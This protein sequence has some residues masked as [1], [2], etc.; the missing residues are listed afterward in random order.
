M[1]N[2][3]IGSL[4]PVALLLA[5]GLLLFPHLLGPTTAG[6]QPGSTLSLKAPEFIG[7]A[8]AQEGPEGIDIGAKLDAEA[9]ISAYFKATDPINIGQARGA[10]RTIEIETADYIIGSVAVPNYPEHYD[11]HVYVHKDG[12]ILAYYLKDDPASKIVDVR[13]QTI[14]STNLRSAIS[15]VASA[16]GAAFGDVSYYDFRYPNATHLL[17]VAE[18]DD[19]GADFTINPPAEYGYYERSWAVHG[20]QEQLFY[21][22][23]TNYGNSPTYRDGS[24]QI[25]YGTLTA[26]QLLPG[27]THTVYI[28]SG[29]K[30][31]VLI[32]TYRVP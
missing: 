14:Q 27:T 9:G 17:L 5:L 8:Y 20:H 6:S 18:D 7:R 4:L 24:W 25:A 13:G 1:S 21:V 22:D 10:Y 23:G 32:I 30:Y 31:G 28:Y 2:H 26:S 29:N 12:W 16:A 19:N 15:V 3:K 11:A